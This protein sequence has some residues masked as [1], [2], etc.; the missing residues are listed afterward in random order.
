[1]IRHEIGARLGSAAQVDSR[2]EA[3]LGGFEIINR[4]RVECWSPATVKFLKTWQGHGTRLYQPGEILRTWLA[5]GRTL[6]EQQVAYL[7][8]PSDIVW[9][10]ETHNLV[11]NVGLD[12][13]LQRVWKSSAFTASDFCGLTDGTPTIVAGDTMASHAGWTEPTIYSEATRQS[14]TWGTVASQ[15]VDNSASKASFSINA[16]GTIG[17][18]FASDNNT[19]GGTTGIL[20]GAAAFTGGDKSVANLDTLNVTLTSTAASP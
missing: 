1:M 7:L 20:M 4:Y 11:V 18:A 19:K 3:A 5:L 6:L 12:E 8:E 14:I 13:I 15:S 10:D 16:S 17:G 2:P 9:V